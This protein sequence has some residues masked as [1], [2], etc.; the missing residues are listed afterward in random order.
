MKRQDT[1][2]LVKLNLLLLVPFLIYGLYKNG[3]LIYTKG[4][5]NGY[6]LFKPLYLV[7]ISF[8]IK[9][10]LDLIIYHKIKIDYNFV[11]LFLV[12]LIMP[13]NV[14]LII[15]T[16]TLLIGYLITRIISKYITFNKVC[17]MYLLIILVTYLAFGL[18]FR[19]PLE[20]N[21]TFSFSVMD[22][23]MGRSIGGIS[24]TSIILSLLVFS[25]YTFNFYYKKDIPLF[26][27][28]TYLILSIIYFIFS[29]DNS[30]IINSEVVFGSIFVASLPNSS[31][32]KRVHQIIYGV[33]IGL[34]TF[35]LIFLT[36]KIISIYLAILVISLLKNVKI[37]QKVTK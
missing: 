31:P 4:L 30:L 9:I 12:A 11:Y 23:L 22:I 14:N 1:K 24:S 6:M 3:Y 17:F 26:I 28:L 35:G 21:F 20:E 10:V 7:L 8:M 36:N 34:L 33:S 32:Y 2:T 13:Y 16:I 29:K 19:S 25:Y 15:Y 37:R 18:D 5:I 27:N